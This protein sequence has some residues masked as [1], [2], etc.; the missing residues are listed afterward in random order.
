MLKKSC[1]F[2][3]FN[4]WLIVLFMANKMVIL[5]RVYQSLISDDIVNNDK[6]NKECQFRP[7][8]QSYSSISKDKTR[9]SHVW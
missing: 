9:M 1:T 5:S 7:F 2:T 6:I 8:G 4:T 3:F